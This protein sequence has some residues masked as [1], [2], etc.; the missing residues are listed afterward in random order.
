MLSLT[1]VRGADRDVEGWGLTFA[2]QGESYRTEGNLTDRSTHSFAI[3]GGT[4]GFEGGLE[5]SG[6]VGVRASLG[7][8]HGPLARLGIAGSLWGN[9]LLYSSMLELPQLQVGYQYL[10]GSTVLEVAARVGPVLAGRY[11]VGDASSRKLGSAFE[12]GGYAAIHASGV[13]ITGSLARFDAMR[14]DGPGPVDV[15]RGSLCTWVGNAGLCV[16]GRYLRGD[17]SPGP[18]GLGS[19]THEARS[20]YGGILLGWAVRE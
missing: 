12:Y 10:E 11:N 1:R 14:A 3:G 4:A 8:N 19:D 2:G 20:L 18:P 7:P 17:V 5:T 16:D 13:H 9:S 6:A 15:A